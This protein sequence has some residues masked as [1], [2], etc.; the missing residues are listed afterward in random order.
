MPR[1]QKAD[2][3]SQAFGKNVRRIREE[4]EL[5]IEALAG[6]IV[7]RSRTDGKPVPMDAKSL[8]EI[9]LGWY[10]PTIGLAA[11]IAKALG[12][13]LADLMRDS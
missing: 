2:S 6:K 10:S 4:Q 3:A 13:P 11:K 8:G 7:T 9:E 1:R 5:S 12:V